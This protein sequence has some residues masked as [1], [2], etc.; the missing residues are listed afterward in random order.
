MRME[1]KRRYTQREMASGIPGG[2][3]SQEGKELGE[4]KV[5]GLDVQG[6]KGQRSILYPLKE[7]QRFGRL[8]ARTGAVRVQC[9]VDVS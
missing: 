4:E 7:P 9:S 1:G 2:T 8:E 6:T 5:T 3:K